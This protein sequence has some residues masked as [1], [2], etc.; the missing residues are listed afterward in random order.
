[1]LKWKTWQ[2][3]W[4][5]QRTL[6]IC[7]SS[8]C[9]CH[10]DSSI[11]T[12]TVWLF[13]FCT[14]LFFSRVDSQI[15]R[16]H[17]TVFFKKMIIQDRM[18]MR[19]RLFTPPLSLQCLQWMNKQQLV[20]TTSKRIIKKIT[21]QAIMLTVCC[22]LTPGLWPPDQTAFLVKN[23]HASMQHETAHLK[24]HASLHSTTPVENSVRKHGKI[25]LLYCFPGWVPL[26]SVTLL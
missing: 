20:S 3:E 9:F 21:L 12:T 26:K 4:S 2:Q 5:V 16:N 14:W 17:Y 6:R 8:Q 11:V 24:W 10:R 25:H 7:V 18:K 15:F 22:C 13:T 19:M 1:M 23:P